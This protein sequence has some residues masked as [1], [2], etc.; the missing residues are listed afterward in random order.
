ML[1]FGSISRI[2]FMHVIWGH[3]SHINL[4]I[5]CRP[6]GNTE[7]RLVPQVKSRS[8]IHRIPRHCKIS[9][10]RIP[11][12]PTLSQNFRIQDPLDPTQS[13]NFRIQDPLDPM[14]HWNFRIQD[15]L[16]P[17]QNVNFRIQ[18]PSG[19]HVKS[20]LKDLKYPV[21]HVKCKRDR[22]P[23]NLAQK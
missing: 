6:M 8:K 16:E 5:I 22:N 4:P 20:K 1:T 15:P 7:S 13:Q 2:F 17:T 3:V 9:G 18:H 10:S 19:S 11:L 14:Q 12:D 23:L 21:S